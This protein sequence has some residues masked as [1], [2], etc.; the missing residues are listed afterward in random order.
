LE[1]LIEALM[2]YRQTTGYDNLTEYQA[3]LVWSYLR[4]IGNI[5]E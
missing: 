5:N 4:E 3:Q 2:I 1:D